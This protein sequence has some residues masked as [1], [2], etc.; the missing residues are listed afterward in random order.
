MI[1]KVLPIAIAI[2]ITTYSCSSPTDPPPG[3]GPDTTSQNFTFETYEFGDGFAS[4]SL[5]DVWIFDE[6]NIWAVGWV[7]ETETG[8][9]TNIM[10]W[11]GTSWNRRGP[12]FTT[13]GLEGI[14]AYDSSHIYLASGAIRNY[15]NG[16]FGAEDLTH[17]NFDQG[18]RVQQLWGSSLSNIYGVGPW[19]IIVH[20]DGSTWRKIDF[21]TEWY[22]YGVTGSGETGIAYAVAR[23]SNNSKSG[24]FEIKDNSITMIATDEGTNDFYTFNSVALITDNEIWAVGRGVFEYKIAEGEF[25]KIDDLGNPPSLGS[26]SPAAPNDIYM[27]GGNYDGIPVLIHYNGLSF[28]EIQLP[29]RNG[30]FYNG[31]YSTSTQSILTSFSENKA[32]LV[33]TKRN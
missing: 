29:E 17:L 6:N 2:L 12:Q 14:W 13:S 31:S 24:L 20:Y 11:D 30:M 8:P 7:G 1:Y 9:T 32:Y 26:I 27:Y 5:N 33:I 15:I 28:K 10:H 23:S 18:Q 4:S 22:F 16:E 25:E 19:G 21:S 3:S